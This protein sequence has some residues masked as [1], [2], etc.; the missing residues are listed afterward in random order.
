MTMLFLSIT[1]EEEYM[2]EEGEEEEEEMQMADSTSQPAA[3]ME[4]SDR[5]CKCLIFWDTENSTVIT[6]KWGINMKPN[7]YFKQ[8]YH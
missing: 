2:E 1:V 6:L 3:E 7:E 5:Y 8:C 4:E